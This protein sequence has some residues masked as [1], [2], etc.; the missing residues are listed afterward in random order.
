V[1]L[2]Q[3]PFLQITGIELCYV[4]PHG[5]MMAALSQSDLM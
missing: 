1:A 2:L 3:N 4:L 5:I